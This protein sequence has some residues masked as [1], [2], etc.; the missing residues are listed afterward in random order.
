LE[1]DRYSFEAKAGQKLSFEVFARRAWSGLDPI[2]R[3]V[4]DKGGLISE[5]DD[6]SFHRVTSADSWLE[7]WSAPADGTYFLEIRDLHLRGGP[8]C[9][10]AIEVPQAEAYFQLEADTDKTL[11]A[12]GVNSVFYVRALRKNG[13]AGEIQLGVEGLPPGVTAVAGRIL[14]DSRDGCVIL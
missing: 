13:F 5:V 8:Q 2:I 6:M 4:N 3:I 11:L 7:N 10:Y 9:V 14:A 1:T 12:P